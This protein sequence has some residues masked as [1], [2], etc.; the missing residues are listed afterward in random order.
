VQVELVIQA[1][2]EPD[3]NE[4]ENHEDVDRPLLREPETQRESSDPNSIEWLDEKNPKTVR[5]HEPDGQQDEHIPQ[6]CSPVR[7]FVTP[8]RHKDDES[9][10]KT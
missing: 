8:P 2:H 5:H 7:L 3:I 4:D 6:V 10:P 1:V 9:N